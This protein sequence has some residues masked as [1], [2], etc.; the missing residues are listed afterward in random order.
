MPLSATTYTATGLNSNTTY[1][2][3]VFAINEGRASSA[4]SGS[5]TTAAPTLS[6]IK[7]VGTGTNAMDYATLTDAFAAINTN[8]LAGNMTLIL[9]TTYSATDA[10]F[11][12]T[13]PGAGAV[14]AYTINIYPSVT[15]LSITSANATGTINLDG[16]K[17][18]VFDGRVGGSG[19]A[20]DL[21]IANTNVAAY[22]IQF[23][24]STNHC[25][26][27]YCKINSVN[28]ATSSGTIVFGTTTGTTGNSNNTIDNC[29]IYDGASTPYNAI[30]ASGSTST[31]GQS[32]SSNTI[33]NCNIYNFF[34]GAG[35]DNG[36]YLSSGNTDWTITGNS[37][38]QTST[39][40]YTL[41]ASHTAIYILSPLGNN[42]NILNNFIGGGDVNCGGTAWTVTGSSFHIM[43][44]IYLSAGT[45][46]ASSVQ[47]NTINNFNITGYGTPAQTSINESFDGINIISGNVNVGDNTGN[48]IGN[49]TIDKI[50]FT[51]LQA[52][53]IVGIN[54]SSTGTIN[55]SNNTIYGITGVGNSTTIGA[56]ITGIQTSGTA[57]KL[58]H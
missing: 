22:A 49:A 44:G 17:N 25:V 21:I 55:I 31:P 19:S 15:G 24:N 54:S 53:T 6:G 4:L 30:Y 29:N 43:M 48:T 16:C 52:G 40:N 9:N 35:A 2:W 10:T 14:G 39:R 57:G 38:Y 3:Q 42:F 56:Y 20:K 27:R 33:S 36:I 28:H 32:N 37:F 11:P 34:Y 5:Q 1:Y 51:F 26:F 7:Y 12:I 13:G 8:G 46:T 23:I 47:G 41:G 50:K 58:Y 45:N 18:I